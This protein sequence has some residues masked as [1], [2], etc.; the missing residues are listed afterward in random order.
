MGIDHQ[1]RDLEGGPEDDVG[2][3]APDAGEGSQNAAK[4]AG[5]SP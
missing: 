3:L 5:T 4:E 1:G 2:G